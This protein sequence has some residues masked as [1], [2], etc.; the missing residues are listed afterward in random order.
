LR[1]AI[2]IEENKLNMNC[3]KLIWGLL[4]VIFI[5]P[6][7]T[8][9]QIPRILYIAPDHQTGAMYDKIRSDISSELRN[10]LQEK[11]VREISNT[12]WER[13][14]NKKKLLEN[15]KVNY[16]LK[17][18]Q[19]PVIKGTDR[20][21]QIAYEMMYADNVYQIHDLTWNN[22]AYMLELNTRKEPANVKKVVS[23]V[24]D[25]IDFFLNSS[26]D[27]WERKFRPRIKIDGFET[28][29][30]EVEDVDLN[31]FRRWLN[32]ILEDKYS[33]EPNYVFYYSRKYD[34]QYP[35]NS[36]YQISGT[37]SKYGAADDNL[38]KVLITVEFPEA[39]DDAAPTVIHSE[40]FSMD[41]KRKDELVNNVIKVLEENINYYGVE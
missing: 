6:I 20:R 23:D 4:L 34:K 1:A 37:F 33:V 2:T 7:N 18:D 36:L 10:C 5:L 24:C 17:L 9:A 8:L 21:I 19:L 30:G 41:E 39:I 25:E 3:N 26:D 35:E 14:P 27:P 15:L 31:A 13:T 12:T 38:V 28:A 11:W 29:S 40:E 22:S 16:V 32:K